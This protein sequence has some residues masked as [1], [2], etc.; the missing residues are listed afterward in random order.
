LLVSRDI[1]QRGQRDQLVGQNPPPAID[2][3]FM[4]CSG[5]VCD[6]GADSNVFVN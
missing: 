2:T 6:I 3:R 4:T 1:D 5:S